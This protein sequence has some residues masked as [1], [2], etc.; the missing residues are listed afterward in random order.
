MISIRWRCSA[1]RWALGLAICLAGALI[2]GTGQAD[3]GLPRPNILLVMTDDQG[4]WDTGATGNPHIDTPC[5]DR[6]AA[7]GTQ[8]RRYYAAPV[9]A[10]TRA[11]MMTGRY[12]LRTGLYNTRFG[13][14]SLGTSEITV[15]Q[16]LKQAGYR[17][18]L[19]GKWHLGMYPGYQPQER[20]FDQFFGHYH[21]HIERYDFPD[22]LYHNGK[23]V[24][25]RGYVTDLFTDAAMDFIQAS[26]AADAAR[27]FFCALMYNAPHSPFLLDTSHSRQPD[28]DKLLEKYL[29][30]GLPLREARIYGMI[31]RIDQ[32]LGRL[33]N[34]LDQL[35]LADTT[36]VLFTGDN[37]GVS[38]YW[39]G[40]MNGAK[41][42][43]YEG[44]VRA[45]FFVRWPGVVPAGGVVDAQVSH[46]DLLPTFCEL[47]GVDPP[48][49]RVLDGRSLVPLLKAG[50]GDRHHPY[51]YHTW[52]RYFPNPDRRWGI[53]DPRWKLI[54]MFGADA[55]PDPA[56]W[57]LFD[58]QNDPG[59]S[60]NVAGQHPETVARLRTEFVRWF[61]EVTDG[62]TYQPIPIPVGHPDQNPVKLEPSWASWEGPHVRYTFDGYD[63]DTIDSWKESGERATWRIEVIR[64]GRYAVTL[65][66]GCRPQHAGGVLEIAA[67][68]SS[69]R[70][71]VQATA[72]AEQFT[73]FPAGVLELAQG[74][75]TLTAR[76]VHAADTEL[77]RL[78][79]IH[80]Q[81]FDDQG[82]P[83]AR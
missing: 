35:G 9:C 79:A 50:Q 27:P 19:F 62:I 66:Y 15:A 24:Q 69:I 80:L 64:P 5:M 23:P 30:R 16:L 18:G 10:P 45:P 3:D 37:G 51:V 22:Q 12:Y 41:S 47:A 81:R 36:L 46:V 57:R 61:D 33:L 38:R 78:N 68:P 13:G 73:R 43:M 6:L 49:D 76:V 71:T 20:G 42:S 77:M 31:E 39:K 11:G 34:H 53:S 55:E 28:G 1:T 82:T 2:A 48:T 17:T 54:G 72:T 63:W 25:A 58:L 65:G 52:D 44:G 56:R 4:Y 74:E 7:D 83:G 67:G 21:G 29:Q 8:F 40:G 26:V 14:D 32:N 59:E 70:H 75:Q 60:D